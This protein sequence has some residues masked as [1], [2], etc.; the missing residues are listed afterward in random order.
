M[1]QCHRT[2]STSDTMTARARMIVQLMAV[3]IYVHGAGRRSRGEC[4]LRSEKSATASRK[5]ERTS[6]FESIPSENGC[7]FS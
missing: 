1:P 6:C 5:R 7:R 3:S 2:N 4:P